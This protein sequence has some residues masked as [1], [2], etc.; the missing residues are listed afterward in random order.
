MRVLAR[1]K[2]PVF[3]SLNVFIPLF[4]I[5]LLFYMRHAEFF[6]RLLYGQPAGSPLR[7]AMEY[8]IDLLFG[9]GAA[10]FFAGR[11]LRHRKELRHTLGLC[12][13][14]EVLAEI[15]RTAFIVNAAAFPLHL[16]VSFAGSLI[17]FTVVLLHEKAI[18]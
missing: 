18:F 17:A 2:R 10:V 6:V 5:L 9:Y 15:F 12:L 13:L 14:L 1:K 16:F 3:F 8:G 7:L 4:G 11:L